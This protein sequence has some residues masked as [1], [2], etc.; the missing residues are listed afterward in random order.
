MGLGPSWTTFERMLDGVCRGAHQRDVWVIAL[1]V[2]CGAD[3]SVIAAPR[4]RP[5]PAR[6]GCRPTPRPRAPPAPL[7]APTSYS[8]PPTVISSG[9]SV[10]MA[11]AALTTSSKSRWTGSTSTETGDRLVDVG[12]VLD[13]PALDHHGGADLHH[14]RL[15]ARFQRGD[16]P[17]PV[18]RRKPP[19]GRRAPTSRNSSRRPRSAPSTKASSSCAVRRASFAPGDADRSR[20]VRGRR[21]PVDESRGELARSRIRRHLVG[22]EPG[23]EVRLGEGRADP[24]PAAAGAWQR[25]VD[26]RVERADR[27]EGDRQQRRSGDHD[28]RPRRPA[29]HRHPMHGPFPARGAP[30]CFTF[31]ARGTPR[32][33]PRPCRPPLVDDLAAPA[34]ERGEPV[35]PRLERLGREAVQSSPRRP[36]GAVRGCGRSGSGCRGTSCR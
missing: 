6:G 36:R 3:A 1:D 23:L 8:S 16:V 2:P 20:E 30:G 19:P 4:R 32:H 12:E 5:P 24:A 10:S 26:L 29:C 17:R 15:V 31:D 21:R 25:R 9:T 28:P 7:T 13:R 11:A 22:V 14:Q 27:G 33:C 34:E 18:R 35:A